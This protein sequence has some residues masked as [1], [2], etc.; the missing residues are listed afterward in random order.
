V[1]SFAG[2]GASAGE[3]GCRVQP[4]GDRELAAQLPI[5]DEGKAQTLAQGW[6]EE[7]KEAIETSTTTDVT[8]ASRLFLAL[9]NML[10][11]SKAKAMAINCIELM[12][13]KVAPP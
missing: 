1:A 12:T 3:A 5:I 11:E 6:V 2:P 7:A 8:D 13:R 9:A 4:C 10:E